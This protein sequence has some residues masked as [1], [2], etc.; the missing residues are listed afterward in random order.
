MNLTACKRDAR[1]KSYGYPRG[2][3]RMGLA[4]VT[5]RPLGQSPG[6]PEQLTARRRYP[7]CTYQGQTHHAT[8]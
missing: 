7:A 5:P 4:W 3:Q 2:V 8:A 1:V 6:L